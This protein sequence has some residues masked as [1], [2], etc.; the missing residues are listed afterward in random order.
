MAPT[1]LVFPHADRLAATGAMAVGDEAI[2]VLLI[3]VDPLRFLC[4]NRIQVGIGNHG[5]RF[6]H[7][8]MTVAPAPDR[9]LERR[10]SCAWS[11]R[12][13]E[14]YTGAPD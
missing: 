14:A 6:V 4:R 10:R 2:V 8:L 7:H 12:S 5:E 11:A 9:F 3:D 1:L 13:E